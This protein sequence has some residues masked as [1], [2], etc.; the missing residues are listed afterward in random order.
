VL[1]SWLGAIPLLALLIGFQFITL[2][3]GGSVRGAMFIEGTIAGLVG[4]YGL[5]R[6]GLKPSE[7]T[8]LT[9][10]LGGRFRRGGATPGASTP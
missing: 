7:R 1:P 6:F 3:P 8:S 4:A 5:W 2:A 10:K 9:N